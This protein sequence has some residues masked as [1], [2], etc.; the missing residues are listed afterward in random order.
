MPG[1][2][3]DAVRKSE[4]AERLRS[5]GLKATPQ[6][7][8]IFQ[9]IL[10]R[11][12]HPTAEAIFSAVK[13]V[14]P[15]ISFNTVYHTLQALTE[16]ELVNVIRPVV[17]AARYDPITDVHGHFMCSQCKRID[18]QLLEDPTLKQ[19][20]SEVKASGRYWVAQSQILWVGLCETCRD[21]SNSVETE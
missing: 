12:D 3:D 21:D 14:H 20:D 19:I 2:A 18:D 9:E 17:D 10:S 4:I 11:E 5:I 7:I 8:V 15:T 16:K 6:R 13:K 1:L